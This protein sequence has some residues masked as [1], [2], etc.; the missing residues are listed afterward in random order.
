MAKKSNLSRYQLLKN[1][2]G[3][4]DLT[5]AV[6][7][8][9]WLDN[10]GYQINMVGSTM[11]GTFDVQVSADYQQDEFGNVQNA[12]NWI[13]LPLSPTATVTAGTPTNIYIDVTQISAPYIRLVYKHTSGSGTVAAFI[14][15]KV[16]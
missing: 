14:T 13:P 9:Q 4:G 2:D 10:I 11:T 16:L 12:G 5:G 8:I 7:C 15:A 3:S 1:A 6:T